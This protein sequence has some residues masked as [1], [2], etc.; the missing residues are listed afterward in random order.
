[1]CRGRHSSPVA[2]AYRYFL[3]LFLYQW[4]LWRCVE[5]D[6]RTHSSLT[7]S[8]L[9]HLVSVLFSTRSSPFFLIHKVLW[10]R[11]IPLNLLSRSQ[12]SVWQSQRV[13]WYGHQL[14]HH[15]NCVLLFECTLV[16]L[17]CNNCQSVS[18]TV[19]TS[20]F[21]SM[22]LSVQL[23]IVF[24]VVMTSDLYELSVSLYDECGM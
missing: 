21:Y 4:V 12:P 9:L 23:C 14:Y 6:I 10:W 8:T 5:S 1:M 20:V 19:Y 24:L 3:C 7:S 2:V 15:V 22:F 18:C 17:M 13:V 11:A 16:K